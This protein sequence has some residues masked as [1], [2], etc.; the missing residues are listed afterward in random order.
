MGTDVPTA[1]SYPQPPPGGDQR[2]A[3][4]TCQAAPTAQ[5]SFLKVIVL[6]QTQ[7]V[8]EVWTATFT[9]NRADCKALAKETAGLRS[10]TA[11]TGTWQARG[12]F[13]CVQGGGFN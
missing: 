7:L 5:R 6:S 3:A 2:R 9:N 10:G 8:G 12:H 11:A 13:Q 4:V 1:V